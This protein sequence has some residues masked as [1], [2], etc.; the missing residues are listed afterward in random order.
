MITAQ[1][2]SEGEFKRCDPPCSLQDM[3]QDTMTMLDRARQL[4]GIPFKLNCAYRSVAWDK[5]KGRSGNS[6]HT[7]GYA[8]DIAANNSTTR[9]KVVKGLIGAG[10]N[11][12]GI[13]KTFV[14]AD[15]DPSLPQGVMFHYY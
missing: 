8:V 1:Y 11:R 14:H 4:A 12:I 2:F 10:F 6:A 15:N 3:K 5:A 7:R 13:G 9:L